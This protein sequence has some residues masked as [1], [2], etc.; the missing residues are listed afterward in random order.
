MNIHSYSEIFNLG[1]RAIADLLK[2]PVI[3]EEKV[4]GSQFSFGKKDGELWARSKGQELN[5]QA[6][7]KMFVAG[8]NAVN[9]LN[10]TD[11]WI[12][13]GEY[14]KSPKHNALAYE[15]IPLNHVI[16]FDIE[17]GYYNFLSRLEKE[18]E[19]QRVGLEVVPILFRGTIESIE[20]FNSLLEADSILGGQK[21]E[22]VVIK[23]EKYDLFGRD[24]KVLMGKYVS[25]KYREIQKVEWKKDNPQQSDILQV[26]AARITTAARW[27]KAI[28]H[29]REAG[30]I[31]DDPK[32]IGM[33][34]REIPQDIQKE[35]VDEIK[36]A[37]WKWAWP[38]LSRM[39]TRG[40]PEWY[41]EKLLARAFDTDAQP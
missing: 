1:H 10:L 26:I 27:E 5:M 8:V 34:I 36:D 16:I 24:K 21:I 9:E 31:E 40:M 19:A 17:R 3:I 6:P 28:Q 35:C 37:L 33:L 25:E 12:Y 13:R 38:Q 18:D 32:D 4:D 7:E 39:S 20:T 15:R 30:L 11:G 2:Y 14:L 41:K 22:G 29:L 23:P